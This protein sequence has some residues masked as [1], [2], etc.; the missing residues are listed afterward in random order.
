MWREL[1]TRAD[2]LL[3]AVELLDEGPDA[4]LEAEL[5]RDAASLE[6]D[7]RRE[8]TALLFS[9]EY[10]DRSALLM[11][12]AGAGGH[13]GDRLGR[14]APADVP[15]LGRAASVPDRDPRPAGRASRPA[16]RA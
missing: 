1:L 15:A 9:G 8:R 10:D 7:F 13:R 2:D 5:E 14:D 11:I 12:S 3:A 6:T 16:S 4:D